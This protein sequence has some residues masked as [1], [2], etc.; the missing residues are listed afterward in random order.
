MID[1]SKL[2]RLHSLCNDYYY[3][4]NESLVNDE[5]Y[6]KLSSFLRIEGLGYNIYNINHEKKIKIEPPML[7]IKSSNFSSS[8]VLKDFLSRMKKSNITTFL[9]QP[10]IDGMAVGVKLQKNLKNIIIYS[11]GNGY[12]GENIK[13][14]L[15]HDYLNLNI[16]WKNIN[17]NEVFRGELYVRKTLFLRYKMSSKFSNERTFVVSLVRSKKKILK[18]EKTLN[19]MYYDCCTQ[20]FNSESNKIQY[21]KKYVQPI[22]FIKVKTEEITITKIQ[23]CFHDWS[24]E[25]DC[26]LDGIVIKSN[27]CKTNYAM[28]CTQK[29]PKFMLALKP[30]SKIYST[31]VIKHEMT[32]G[33]TGLIGFLI[34]VHP[35][36][37]SNRT[38]KKFYSKKIICSN[39]DINIQLSGGL[40]PKLVNKHV[41]FAEMEKVCIYCLCE[42]I[43]HKMQYYCINML[44]SEKFVNSLSFFFNHYKIAL[45]HKVLKK[46]LIINQ[47]NTITQILCINKWSYIK[48]ISLNKVDDLVYQIKNKLLCLD[49]QKIIENILKISTKENIIY[50]NTEGFRRI[51]NIWLD[52]IRV[53]HNS[54]ISIE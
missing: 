12:I 32:V 14:I 37:I 17:N 5:V 36:I 33:R 18:Y 48:N 4:K 30:D 2:I 11:R 25:L 3:F 43:K 42:I 29:Y 49:N 40:I 47:Y 31:K 21:I 13:N 53:Y 41:K 24:L 19:I 38:I 34:W 50:N 44:C 7:S 54:F 22:P 6:D 8:K 39:T 15:E 27:D 28:G 51:L 26:L 10:K 16:D 23:Q 9:L 1:R 46:V 52:N 45:T 35:I 20:K